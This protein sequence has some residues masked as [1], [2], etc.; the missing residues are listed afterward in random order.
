VKIAIVGATGMIGLHAARAVVARSHELVVA[1]RAS[2]KLGALHG[3]PFTPVEVT[4]EDRTS[5]AAALRGV[6]GVIHCAGYYPT[7]PLPWAEDVRIAAAGLNAF[8]DGAGDAGVSR[9]VYVGAAIALPRDPAG[10]PGTEKLV[11]AE[12]PS[13]TTPYVQVKCEMDRIARARA[14]AGLPVVIGIPAM[15][16]GDFDR[17]PT[18]GQLIVD[19]ANQNLPAYIK[20]RRNVVYAGDA[21][22]GLVLA[23]EKGR[24]GE[25]YLL[26]GTNVTMDDLVPLIAR[27]AGV[28]APTRVL[29]LPVARFVSAMQVLRYRLFG[30]ALPRLSSTAIAVLSSGQFLDGAKARAE[31]DYSPEVSLEATVERSLRW[32]QANGYIKSPA[33]SAAVAGGSASA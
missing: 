11:Y 25:R 4:I 18:T 24:V 8:F 27:V 7:K 30:G 17:G 15:C 31:L 10:A 32:F 26:T 33:A 14:A 21:G 28:R 19:I 29:P 12:R 5:V 3:L 9:V 20:G 1:H 6:D 22:R 23:C 16:F 13:D 2:S